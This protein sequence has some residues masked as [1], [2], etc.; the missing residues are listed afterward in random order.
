MYYTMK[1]SKVKT[2]F[3]KFSAVEF[4]FFF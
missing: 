2:F 4:S 1:K 3:E